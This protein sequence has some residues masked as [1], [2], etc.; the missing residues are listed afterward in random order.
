L[1]KVCKLLDEGYIS[2]YDLRDELDKVFKFI[3]KHVSKDD[4]TVRYTQDTIS[5]DDARNI[6]GILLLRFIAYAKNENDDEWLINSLSDILKL[7]I[8]FKHKFNKS[9]KVRTFYALYILHCSRAYIDDLDPSAG[10]RIP[11]LSS[12]KIFDINELDERE[13]VKFN[14][15]IAYFNRTTQTTLA[16]WATR[17]AL[18]ECGKNIDFTQQIL[19]NMRGSK[20]IFVTENCPFLGMCGINNTFYLNEGLLKTRI[21]ELTAHVVMNY[22]HEGFRIAIRSIGN[23]LINLTP[24]NKIG[25]DN[26]DL[27]AGCLLQHFLLGNYQINYTEP[28]RSAII[29]D[30]N[31]WDREQSLFPVVVIQE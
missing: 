11:I 17:T 18:L 30:I 6:L 7:Y 12:F 14:I 27:E 21:E 16:N 8:D 20:V 5:K 19:A 2:K 22:Y 10:R 23:N 13:R 24:R 29:N 31:Q 15:A 4:L 3:L 9:D 25:P 26:L 1:E 28:T